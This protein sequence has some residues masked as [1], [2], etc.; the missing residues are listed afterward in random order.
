MTAEYQEFSDS[1]NVF[2]PPLKSNYDHFKSLEERK[3]RKNIRGIRDAYSN[4]LVVSNKSK[5]LIHE[6]HRSAKILFT[7]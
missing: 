6:Y 7:T 1:V 3:Y 4:I 5:Y 2:H